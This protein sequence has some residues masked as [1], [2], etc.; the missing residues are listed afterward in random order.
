MSVSDHI[1]SIENTYKSAI[2]TY[3]TMLEFFFNI[4]GLPIYFVP[5]RSGSN[6]I[7]ARYKVANEH[8]DKPE[9]F[10]YPPKE[11][12]QTF[13]R[14]NRPRQSLFYASETEHAC[15]AEMMRFWG[16][17]FNIGDKIKVAMGKW[18][19]TKDIKL[20]IIPDPDNESELNQIIVRQLSSESLEFWSYISKKFKTTGL[21]EKNIYEFTSAFSNSIYLN[22]KR[23]DNSVNGFIFGSVQSPN[24]LNLALDK[25]L[26]DSEIL[27]LEQLAEMQCTR[28]GLDNRELP[29]YTEILGSRKKGILVDGK[30]KW[31]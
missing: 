18:R 1:L 11:L 21:E 6:L 3:E 19:L 17:E 4:D 31:K 23:N 26:I 14:M 25:E 12:V 7:R 13:S 15:L 8:F 28:I 2:L 27:I 20:I 16:E 5:L 29:Y 9:E 24:T 30:I 10:S 22:A